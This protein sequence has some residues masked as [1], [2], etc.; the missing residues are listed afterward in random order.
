MTLWWKL[1][2]MNWLCPDTWSHRVEVVCKR[3]GLPVQEAQIGFT[4]RW[5]RL[6]SHLLIL[7]LPLPNP[8]F[9]HRTSWGIP[10]DSLVHRLFCLRCWHQSLHPPSREALKNIA[11]DT[12]QVGKNLSR[13]F[14]FLLCLEST[15]AIMLFQTVLLIKALT[16]QPKE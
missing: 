11:R 7:H 4:N 9:T 5:L 6:W 12:L 8:Q 3:R 2:P 13:T 1:I 16:L 10:Y 14:S 15:V